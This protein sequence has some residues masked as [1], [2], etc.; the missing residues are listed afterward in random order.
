MTSSMISNTSIKKDKIG[1]LIP[2]DQSKPC[3]LV[4]YHDL[5]DMQQL[6][7]GDIQ[8]IDIPEKTFADHAFDA[9]VCDEEGK[10]S[11]K[12]INVRFGQYVTHW[13]NLVG[14]LLLIHDHC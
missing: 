11:G 13:N 1:Y 4:D 14:D 10:L 7:G 8:I 9:V 6:V 3:K 5:K 2:E 12:G